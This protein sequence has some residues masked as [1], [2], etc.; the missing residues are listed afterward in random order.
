MRENY[1]TGIPWIENIPVGWELTK[2]G[3][4]C[5]IITDGTHQTPNYIEEGYP[6]ISIKDISSGK[7]DFSDVKYISKEEHELLYAHAPVKKGDILFT[8]I[9]TL[10]VFV[11]VDTD[12]VFD[13]F[14]SVGMLRLKPNIINSHYL[15][16]YLNSHAVE[17]FIQAIKAGFGTAAPKYNLTDVK[18]TWVIVPPENEQ[19]LIAQFL[20]KQCYEIDALYD[21]VQAEIET[22]EAYKQSVIAEAVTKGLNKHVV[23]KDSGMAWL[24]K[25]PAHWEI[26]PSKYLFK[27]MDGRRRNGDEQLTA[28]QKYGI[29]T[30]ADYME[31][32]NAKVVLATQKLDDWKHV[33]PNDFV[34]SLRSFQGGL[35]MSEISGCITWHYVVLRATH[36]IYPRFYKWLFKSS[37]YIN[38]LQGTCNF[39][40]DGQD[41]RY[42]NFAQVPL[43][44]PPLD[45]QEDIAR[46]LDDRCAEIDKIITHKQEQLTILADY[47]KSLIYEYVTGKKEVPDI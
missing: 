23:M 38:A 9:G 15:I 35:E 8:R 18:K 32:E 27:N 25:L 5:T 26:I 6:F 1:N 30:Q 28:S 29:I 43:Y 10:G 36:K 17:N 45:E 3:R 16:H 12:V 44:I 2:L 37:Q 31:R 39:I 21:D 13:F 14:V 47:K 24:P 20:D 46:F 7:I 40:R 11:E 42:S 41:L 19:N 22:L 4:I 34:I 33:E